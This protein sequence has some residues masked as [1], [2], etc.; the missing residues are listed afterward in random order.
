MTNAYYADIEDGMNIADTDKASLYYYTVAVEYENSG[1]ASDGSI[2]V[3]EG[4]LQ[5]RASDL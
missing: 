4:R 2:P 1:E 3:S 5:D